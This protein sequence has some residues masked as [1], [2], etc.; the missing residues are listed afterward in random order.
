MVNLLGLYIYYGVIIRRVDLIFQYFSHVIKGVEHR[1][2][3]LGNTADGVVFL[4]FFF[5]DR[6]FIFAGVQVLCSFPGELAVGQAGPHLCRY[7]ALSVVQLG[8]IELPG[9]VVIIGPHEL[10]DGTRAFHRPAQ[11]FPCPE[12]IDNAYA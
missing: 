4:Y 12:K 11:E 3:D 6:F 5:E 7:F 1:P 2:Q 10:I 9:E 8:M